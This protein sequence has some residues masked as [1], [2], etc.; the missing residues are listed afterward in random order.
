MKIEIEITKTLDISSL[1]DEIVEEDFESYPSCE[2][3]SLSYSDMTP[4]LMN[5]I[6]SALAEEA[7]KR[8]NKERMW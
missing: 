2:E 4:K 5:K 1:Y 7:M 8:Q 6:F 3:A